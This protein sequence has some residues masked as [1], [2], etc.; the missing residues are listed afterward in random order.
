MGGSPQIKL[1]PQKLRL[2]YFGHCE[3][4]TGSRF[5]PPSS[6]FRLRIYLAECVAR[7][8]VVAICVWGI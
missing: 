4:S 7:Y 8:G 1:S 5:V 3:F 2:T 6:L